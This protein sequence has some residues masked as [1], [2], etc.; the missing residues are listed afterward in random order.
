VALS[1]A[2]FNPSWHLTAVAAC[3]SAVAVH[4]THRSGDAGKRGDGAGHLL[5]GVAGGHHLRR[6]HTAGTNGDGFFVSQDF[7][8][9][10]GTLAGEQSSSETWSVYLTYAPPAAPLFTGLVW[11]PGGA[12]QLQLAGSTNIPYGLLAS[13]NLAMPSWPRLNG[14]VSVNNGQW[15]FSDTNAGLFPFR[16]YRAVWP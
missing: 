15:L 1:G 13:T 8:N 11:Q 14:P 2:A 7:G 16:F 12:L 9:F 6:T 10:P 3:S 5:A 4:H